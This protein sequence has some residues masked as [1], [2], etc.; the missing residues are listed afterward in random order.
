MLAMWGGAYLAVAVASGASGTH[1]THPWLSERTGRAHAF[2]VLDFG[3]VG[4][5]VTKDTAAI[6]KAI[7]AVAV[8]G[9]GAILFPGGRR[10]LTAPFNMTSHCTLFIDANAT[11]L[12][13]T[14]FA[15]WPEIPALPSYGFA[16]HGGTKRRTS[17]IHGQ[18]LTDVVITG[19]NGTVDGQGSAWWEDGKS[20]GGSTP[21]HLIEL[22]WSTD[23]EVSNL[24]LTHSAFWT[25]HPV[26]VV[27]FVAHHL[28]ILN[29]TG[30][31]GEERAHNSDGIDPDSTQNVLIHDCYIRTG[32]DA[33]AI[34]SGWD[35]YGYDYGVA[36]RNITIRDC[37]LSTPCA[38]IAI[39]SEM[40][41]GVSDVHVS[42]CHL[43]ESTAGIHIKTGMGRGGYVHD[44]AFE[45]LTMD[46]CATA[47]MLDTDSGSHPPNDPS[48]HLNMSATPDVR[49]VSVR[50]VTGTGST[51]VAKLQGLA[52]DPL[53]GV[54]LDSVRFDGGAFACS[55]VSGTWRDVEPTPCGLLTP[56]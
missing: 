15:D 32:D 29:P 46:A 34:K 28:T 44:I 49:R 3:A 13:S 56:V 54:V 10:F 25:V 47:I 33:I 36:S 21:P 14:D 39:G 55:N 2:N 17:L 1:S 51:F 38:A 16:K 24:T 45:N 19:A 11:L 18:N 50:R 20:L 31:G 53:A 5:G 12:G 23:V 7:A 22:M 4:D 6:S 40:S 52:Q 26:Y 37:A 30:A 27:G 8:A 48:H 35:E 43:F 42:G 9:S 41:G